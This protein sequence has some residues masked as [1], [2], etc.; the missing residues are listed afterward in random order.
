MAE[1]ILSFKL[2]FSTAYERRIENAAEAIVVH[3]VMRQ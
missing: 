3:A 2:G 1:V